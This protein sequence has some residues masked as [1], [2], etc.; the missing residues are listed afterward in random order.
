M[1][2]FYNTDKD[3][4]ARCHSSELLA[5]LNDPRLPESF[6]IQPAKD[7]PALAIV[8]ADDAC[9]YLGYIDLT[10]GELVLN[11]ERG[12]DD[13]KNPFIDWSLVKVHMP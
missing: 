13:G 8:S 1:A 3:M 12:A 7:Y 10:D 6:L 4:F 11:A 9:W 2:I 5:A